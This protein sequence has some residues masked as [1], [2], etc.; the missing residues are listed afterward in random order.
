LRLG[1]VLLRATGDEL[2]QQVVDLGHL[3]GVLVTEGAAPVDQDPQDG[4]L[5]VIDDG[6]Q[7]GH[8]GAD[9]SHRVRVGGIGL[10]ALS[11]GKHPGPGRQFRWNV[12]ALLALTQWTKGDV[13]AN[14]RTTLDGPDPLRPR[15]DV[16][17]QRG[18]PVPVGAE[19]ACPDGDPSP[20][21][22]SIVTDRLRGSIPITT[23]ANALLIVSSELEPVG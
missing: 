17:Q 18:Q 20:D 8:P 13:P 15:S 2:Q 22:T 12:D 5:L 16:P 10:A 19:P 3:A 14:A 6:S 11:G 9:Q 21:I 7:A 1:Q 23:C 4:K